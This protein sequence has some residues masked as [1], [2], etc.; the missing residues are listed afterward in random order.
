MASK[1]DKCEKLAELQ[2]KYERLEN[3]YNRLLDGEPVRKVHFDLDGEQTACGKSLWENDFDTTE[4]IKK[5][6]LQSLLWQV[7]KH[8]KK[9]GKRIKT[10]AERK[11]TP[12]I[13]SLMN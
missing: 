3:K 1:C 2:A 7:A 10:G 9:M 13:L 11:W 5:S 4:D 8:E 6:H 12:L